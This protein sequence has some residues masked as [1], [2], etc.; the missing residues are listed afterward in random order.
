MPFERIEVSEQDSQIAIVQSICD[1]FLICKTSGYD[2]AGDLT[3]ID[4]VVSRPLGLR[5]LDYFGSGDWGRNPANLQQRTGAPAG[6]YS[7]KTEYI[8]PPY[9]SG[10][11]INF[12]KKISEPLD[13]SRSVHQSY[14]D[15]CI[16]NYPYF[17]YWGDLFETGCAKCANHFVDENRAGRAWNESGG[18]G[19][20]LPD[21]YNP[22]CIALCENGVTI[23]GRIL[24]K[25]GCDEATGPTGPTSSS[26][27]TGPTSS[28]GPSGPTS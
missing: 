27:P 16:A 24:F 23:S 12:T 2:S 5:T 18:G 15:D 21:G 1:D 7:G 14:Y 9:K 4:I 19:G 8:T 17:L 22:K 13:T 6:S 11:K 26:G 3:G 20:G 10:D 25:S 28:S